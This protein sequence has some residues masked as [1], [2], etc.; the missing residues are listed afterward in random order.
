MAAWD[1]DAR[2]TLSFCR[3]GQ[4]WVSAGVC[5]SLGAPHME[6]PVWGGASGLLLMACVSRVA[7][8]SGFSAPRCA[9]VGPIGEG[10]EVLCPLVPATQ[11]GAG[12]GVQFVKE[13]GAG[14]RW[15]RVRWEQRALR[16]PSPLLLRGAVWWWGGGRGQRTR[17]DGGEG[18]VSS[19]NCLGYGFLYYFLLDPEA[20]PRLALLPLALS[21]PCGGAGRCAASPSGGGERCA[22]PGEY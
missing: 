20:T 1:G 16:T 8:C 11:H 6:K 4:G 15:S 22:S 10:H 7:R 13:S 21:T 14:G 3:D 17:G 5:V 19:V 9:R 2:T 18:P 12:C